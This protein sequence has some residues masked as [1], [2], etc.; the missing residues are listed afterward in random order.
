M[1]WGLGWLKDINSKGGLQ[2]IHSDWVQMMSESGNIGLCLYILFAAFLLFKILTITWKYKGDIILTLLG[3]VTAGSFAAC[4]FCM[5]F[6][7]VITYA[8]QGYV[9][10][11]MLF[12]I[13]LKVVDLTRQGV[14]KVEEEIHS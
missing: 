6:D 13:F 8:Q 4:Y 14:F 9:L 10:P 2:L 7:N 5:G 3:G 11:F 12:G 1:W